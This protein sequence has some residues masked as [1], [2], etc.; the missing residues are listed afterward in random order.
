MC[1]CGCVYVRLCVCVDV[2]MCVCVY[3]YMCVCVY[4]CMCVC[5][6]VVVVVVVVQGW[7]QGHYRR[8]RCFPDSKVRI[9]SPP[10]WAIGILFYKRDSVRKII[11]R[12]YTSSGRL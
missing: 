7:K 10:L 8:P 11:E 1:M 5:M 3:V 9:R 4:A 12:V 2:W 6:Y